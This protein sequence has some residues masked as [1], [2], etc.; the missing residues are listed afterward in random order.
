[1]KKNKEHKIG[2][3]LALG[4]LV[5]TFFFFS[6]FTYFITSE[7]VSNLYH[8]RSFANES[9]WSF[10]LIAINFSLIP[11]IVAIVQKLK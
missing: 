11:G 5:Y 7:W 10:M 9:F 4:F 6:F 3:A 8:N 1:M 2:W